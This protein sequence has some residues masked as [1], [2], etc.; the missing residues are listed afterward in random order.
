MISSLHGELREVNEQTATIQ[1]GPIAYDVMIPA[2]DVGRLRLGIGDPVDLTVLHYLESQSNGAVFRPRLIGF[3]N[4]TERSFFELFT[5]VK[6]IGYRKALRALA[7]PMS[8]VARAIAE[9]D[10][11][12]LRALPEI[13]KRTAET[14]V[15]D[16]A[17]RVGDDFAG[18]CGGDGA[19]AEIEGTAVPDGARDAITVLVQLGEARTIAVELVDRVRRADPAITDAD[20]I[21]AAALRLKDTVN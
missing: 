3:A 1:V 5:S 6:G 12:T 15:L 4:E 18:L 16:L 7:M 10:A 21:V 2:G 14:I 20:A 19:D 11:D 9:R 8:T 17:E 13:G